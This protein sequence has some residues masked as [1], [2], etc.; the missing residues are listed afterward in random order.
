MT[1]RRPSILALGKNRKFGL[2]MV[3]VCAAIS[4]LGAASRSGKLVWFAAAMIFLIIALLVP[5]LLEPMRRR[6]IS[7]GSLMHIVVS[8]VILA[9]LYYTVIT[10]IGLAMR[11][12]GMDPLRLRRGATTY[13]IERR[14]P[15]PAPQTM[16]ELY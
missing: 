2:L 4:Q 10:P 13:W 6:W 11:L 1:F 5:R 8:P 14:P 12:F 15:G 3:A 7:L 9:V 16:T